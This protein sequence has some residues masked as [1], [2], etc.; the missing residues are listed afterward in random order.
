MKVK[1]DENVCI[2]CGLC[3]N[4]CPKVF[5]L[6]DGGKSEAIDGSVPSDD[7]NEVLQSIEMCPVGAISED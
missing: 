6:N 2:G 3:M 5:K 1:V 4:V 7:K